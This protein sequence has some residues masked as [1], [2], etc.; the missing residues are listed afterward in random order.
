ML[1]GRQRDT[2]YQGLKRCSTGLQ[3]AST[4]AQAPGQT[5]SVGSKQQGKGPGQPSV[6]RAKLRAAAGWCSQGPVSVRSPALHLVPVKKESAMNQKK[7]N[8]S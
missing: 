5:M 6:H 8:R 7:G 3:R 4:A 2:L 1:P